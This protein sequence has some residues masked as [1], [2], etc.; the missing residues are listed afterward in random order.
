MIVADASAVVG[1]ITARGA[2][3][4]HARERLARRRCHV[5][6]L[7]DIEV[8]AALRRLERSAV[9]DAEHADAALRRFRRLRVVR[10]AHSGLLTRVWELR[11]NLTPYDAVYVALAEHLDVD[12]VTA[13]ERLAAASGPRCRIEVVR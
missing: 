2:G 13:D 4:A 8:P 9:V 12:L 11:H 3:G 7:I 10:H 6:H 1:A 5:P